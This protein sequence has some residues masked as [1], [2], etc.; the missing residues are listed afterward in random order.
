MTSPDELSDD[1]LETL[2]DEL[3]C[4]ADTKRVL[5]NW[6]ILVLPNGRSIT[7]FNA[8][9]ALTQEEL[10]HTRSLYQL[11]ED[12]DTGLDAH[13]LDVGRDTDEIRYA[14]TLTEPPQSWVDYIVTSYLVEHAVWN[15]LRT[16]EDS[17]FAE[18][19]GLVQKIGEEE[20]YHQ[21]YAEGWLE[22]LV[23]EESEE[24]TQRF[25][26]RLPAMY[27][28]LL[29]GDSGPL[30]DAGV[31]TA[32][33]ADAREAFK[34]SVTPFLANQ[35]VDVSGL[36]TDIEVPDSWDASSRR[37]GHEEPTGRLQQLLA[38]E[39]TEIARAIQ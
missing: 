23:E 12:S 29:T 14:K 16:F 37:P 32:D 1:A 19:A 22:V 27:Q 10:G 7:D 18:L 3:L 25:A 20:R 24:V 26:E 28:W 30:V 13:Q 21:M 5:G 4:I 2:T 6:H 39:N 9:S 11:L 36:V 8:I 31:R 34:S 35:G 17:A 15:L 33:V 38:T